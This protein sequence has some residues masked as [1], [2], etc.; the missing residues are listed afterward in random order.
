MK[1]VPE[2]EA[3]FPRLAENVHMWNHHAGHSWDSTI[4]ANLVI[5]EARPNFLVFEFVVG[6][7]HVNGLG[8][9]HGGCV[10]TL[11]DLCSSMAILVSGEN[12]TAWRSPGISTELAVSYIAGAP[13]GAKLRV[14]NELLR[15]G[16]TLA[17][18]YT[19]IYNENGRLCYSGTHTK[20]CLD[21][22]L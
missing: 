21:S 16:K 7:D 4:S 12:M 19:K 22:K 9:L 15:S 13:E 2:V 18:L 11:I 10:A 14:E 1:I 5:T 6:E 3:K 17:N 20:F 8:N